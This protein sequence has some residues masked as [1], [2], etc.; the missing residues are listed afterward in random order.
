M[1]R[2]GLRHT[3]FDEIRKRPDFPRPIYITP[4][5]PGFLEHEL[6]AFLDRLIAER[7]GV[8]A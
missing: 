5:V 8:K 4:R 6:N 1:R 3:A 2:L 7:D